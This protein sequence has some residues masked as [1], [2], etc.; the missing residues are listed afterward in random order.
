MNELR[1]FGEHACFRINIHFGSIY[2]PAITQA[3]SAVEK[4]KVAGCSLIQL[5]SSSPIICALSS[6]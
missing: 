2:P 1:S 5:T 4:Q 6:Y 3:D